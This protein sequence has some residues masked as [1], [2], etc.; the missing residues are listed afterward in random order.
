MVD[1]NLSNL[2]DSFNKDITKV[3]NKVSSSYAELSLNFIIQSVI[4]AFLISQGMNIVE[5][6]NCS[7]S[8][9]INVYKA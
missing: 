5:A 3:V 6:Q 7:N 1:N 2:K 9:L 8:W 4:K